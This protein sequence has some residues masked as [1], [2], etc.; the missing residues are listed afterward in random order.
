MRTDG[1]MAAVLSTFRR[2]SDRLVERASSRRP[3]GRRRTGVRSAR[4]CASGGAF[5]TGLAPWR[6]DVGY[7]LHCAHGLPLE[8]AVLGHTWVVRPGWALG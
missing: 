6:G 4:W 2:L 3:S 8:F 7:G 5:R 1:A